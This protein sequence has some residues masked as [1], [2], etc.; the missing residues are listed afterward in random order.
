[1]DRRRQPG[2]ATEGRTSSSPRRTRVT[3]TFGASSPR[4]SSARAS[5]GLTPMGVHAIDGII[6]L[7]GPIDSGAAVALA[8][9]HESSGI[10]EPEQ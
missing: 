10:D 9:G 1:M 8:F 3:H 4:S 5:C 2:V 6:D 7:G